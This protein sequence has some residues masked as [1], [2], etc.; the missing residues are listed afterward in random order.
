M[1]SPSSTEIVENKTILTFPCVILASFPYCPFK[2]SLKTPSK[3]NIEE[4]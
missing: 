3:Q 1:R 2:S 4:W